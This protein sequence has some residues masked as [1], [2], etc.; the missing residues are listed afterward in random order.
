M[1]GEL[2]MNDAGEIVLLA[3]GKAGMAPECCCDCPTCDCPDPPDQIRL[4]FADVAIDGGC[5]LDGF[6]GSFQFS[7]MDSAGWVS[8]G[9]F[10]GT[11]D[12]DITDNPCT[13]VYEA[14]DS[15]SSHA[16]IYFYDDTGCTSLHTYLDLSTKLVIT[17]YRA[18]EPPPA[19]GTCIWG[20]VIR[21]TLEQRSGASVVAIILLFQ[22][23]VADA[24]VGVCG[25]VPETDNYSGDYDHSLDTDAGYVI[26]TGGTVVATKL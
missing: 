1:P 4:T 6:G 25:D 2:A 10:S 23:F 3:D 11:F 20:W 18:E 7:E 17:M 8:G 14:T 9:I 19:T 5:N 13:W 16:R 15:G 22:C 21:A 12:L 26:C 24:D